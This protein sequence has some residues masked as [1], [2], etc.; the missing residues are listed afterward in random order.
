MRKKFVKSV[1]IVACVSGFA[2]GLA[3]CGGKG[4]EQGGGTEKHT[5]VLTLVEECAAD[6]LTG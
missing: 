2:L 4:G 6:C 3:S 5:H 1:L